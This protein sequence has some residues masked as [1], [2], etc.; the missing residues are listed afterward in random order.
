MMAIFDINCR[1]RDDEGKEVLS[2]A[3]PAR[4]I[5]SQRPKSN[6]ISINVDCPFNTGSH[7]QR[8]KASRSDKVNC[9]YSRDLPLPKGG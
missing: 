5:V 8:C 1:G 4:I 9:P 2:T 7:G 6:F 3:I